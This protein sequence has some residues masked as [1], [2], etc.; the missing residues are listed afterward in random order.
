M[1]RTI[2]AIAAAG[3]LGG[4]LAVG[5][6]SDEPGSGFDDDSD[7]GGSS[8]A[9]GAS[10]GGPIINGSSG[11][12]GSS[13]DSGA[14]SSG[15]PTCATA[16]A[17][18]TRQPI[19]LDI[20]LD[21]SG[22]MDGFANVTPQHADQCVDGTYVEAEFGPDI[23]KY[24]AATELDPLSPGRL[25]GK[26][27]LAARGALKAYFD[28]KSLLAS[29]QLGV[30]LLFFYSSDNKQKYANVPI[31]LLDG[32][33]RD[34]LWAPIKPERFPL[35]G[36]PILSAVQKSTQTL[37]EFMPSGGLAAEG[38]RAILLITDG[39]PSSGTGSTQQVE[40]AV[41]AA[42]AGS[43]SIATAVIGVGN[44]SDASSI[45]DP[46]FLSRL[47]SKG[48]A[49]APGCDA[50][51]AN[52]STPGTSCHL[53]VTPGEKTADVLQQE[54]TQAIDAIAGSLASCELTL[55][56]SSP[57]DPAKVNVLYVDGSGAS[58]QVPQD[59]TNGWTYDNPAD[60]SKVILHGQSCDQLKADAK[61]KVDIVIG[62][63]TG[64]N[65]VH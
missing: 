12:S 22:S 43:P 13:G 49:A 28:A 6:G 63:P 26:K 3:L 58:S 15:G 38:R 46:T 10:S 16:S 61:G 40:D 47:A 14:S 27:W 17:T 20:I 1:Q 50:T 24:T 45:F 19:Y 64:S 34:A 37:S 60:P 52:G 51:W 21:G 5:C 25:T 39:V 32:A 18:T 23:C 35:G 2:W 7:A 59:G 29:D 36:T 30:G 55:D 41:V 33:Q 44:P 4:V 65:V 11:A 8:G 56:K 9:V 42:L 48:G 62:C 54:I 31:A 57:I 53:Q